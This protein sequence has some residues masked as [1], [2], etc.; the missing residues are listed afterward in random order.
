MTGENLR[1]NGQVVGSDQSQVESRKVGGWGVWDGCCGG[2]E[3]LLS[4]IVSFF[5]WL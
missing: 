1:V 4:A 5:C 3:D 2:L